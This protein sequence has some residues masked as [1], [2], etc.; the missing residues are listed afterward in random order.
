[1]PLRNLDTQRG[2]EMLEQWAAIDG[3]R[4]YSVEW[5]GPVIS[6]TG[7]WRGGW[8]VAVWNQ[9]LTAR[10]LVSFLGGNSLMKAASQALGRYQGA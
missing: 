9:R 10:R 6:V 7:G 2:Y 4:R 3:T 1:M 5:A 8:K